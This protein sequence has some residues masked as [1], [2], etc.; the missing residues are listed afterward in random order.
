MTK[1]TAYETW[2]ELGYKGS[3]NSKE[4]NELFNKMNALNEARLDYMLEAICDGLKESAKW[5]QRDC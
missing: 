3:E 1:A 4:F 2:C 5:N